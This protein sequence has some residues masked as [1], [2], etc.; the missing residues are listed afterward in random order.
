MSELDKQGRRLLALLVKQLSSAT[1]GRPNTY[2]TYS[3]V[4]EKLGLTFLGPTYGESLKRQGL[5]NLADWTA[6]QGRA[7]IT[8]LIIEGET[9]LPGKGYFRLFDRTPDDFDWWNN[10][11]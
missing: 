10:Q 2:I 7:G 3:Q 11:I 5:T 1:A 4:H 6:S 8:G 9:L